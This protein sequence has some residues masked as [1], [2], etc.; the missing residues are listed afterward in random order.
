LSGAGGFLTVR[1][2]VIRN[3]G[4]D[5]IDFHTDGGGGVLSVSNTVVSDNGNTGIA[6][7]P[8]GTINVASVTLNRVEMRNNSKYGFF[9]WGSLS[10]PP[11]NTPMSLT[12]SVFESTV[13]GSLLAGLYALTTLNNSF[14]DIELFHSVVTANGVGLLAE[15]YGIISVANSNVTANVWDWQGPNNGLV[16]SYGDNYSFNNVNS[17]GAMHPVPRN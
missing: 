13:S 1:D 2:C 12:A 11:L 3:F 10:T 17:S 7:Y 4:Q 5:G 9:L 16:Q 15:G 14:V 6:Y 8:S